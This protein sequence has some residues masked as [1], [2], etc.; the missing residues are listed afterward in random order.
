MCELVSILKDL[1]MSWEAVR[2]RAIARK[3]CQRLCVHLGAAKA[4]TW[5]KVKDY[6][7]PLN[8][9]ACPPEQ[10]DLRFRLSQTESDR[11]RHVYEATVHNWLHGRLR[12]V[13]SKRCMPFRVLL[14]W[15]RRLLCS[16][17]LLQALCGIVTDLSSCSGQHV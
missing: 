16:V 2:Q 11:V 3:C 10:P 12:Y 7:A 6:V 17:N 14:H 8:L 5:S 15:C 4:Y 1:A 9:P 13:Q